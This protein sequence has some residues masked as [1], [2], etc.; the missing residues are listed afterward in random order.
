[1]SG[2]EYIAANLSLNELRRLSN[3]LVELP[4]IDQN[5]E[6]S[7]KYVTTQDICIDKENLLRLERHEMW[8]K[9]R[10]SLLDILRQSLTDEKAHWATS[11]LYYNFEQLV[12]LKMAASQMPVQKSKP[13][14]FVY[15]MR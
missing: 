7:L 14:P 9:E 8:Q 1:M 2:K 11:F 5:M 10:E 4:Q 13:S 3:V 12:A 15:A 6:A